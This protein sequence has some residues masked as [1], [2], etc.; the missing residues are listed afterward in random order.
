MGRSVAASAIVLS[1]LLPLASQAA[2]PRTKVLYRFYNAGEAATTPAGGLIPDASGALYG[3]TDTGGAFQSGTVFELT[4]PMAGQTAWTER[5]LYSFGNGT[6][7]KAPAA[8]LLM[9]S[10]GDLYGTTPSGSGA[11]VSGTVFELVPPAAGQ[12]VWTEAILH[13][14]GAG[15]DGALPYAGLILDAGGALYGTALAGGTSGHGIVFKLTPPG[16]G[17]TSWTETVLHNFSGPADG[18]YPEG[19]LLLDKSGTL[20][21]TTESGA[22]CCG[23]VFKLS[24]PVSGKTVWRETILHAFTGEPDGDQP[25]SGL[26]MDRTSALYGTTRAGGAGDCSDN[27]GCGTVFKLSPPA[28]GDSGWTE[29]VI[30]PFQGES[31]G[32]APGGSQP[33]G[34]LVIDAL[35]NLYGTTPSGG[36]GACHFGTGCGTVF[37]LTPPTTGETVWTETVLHSF[38]LTNKTAG[39]YPKPGLLR[40]RKGR[41]FGVTGSLQPSD[42]LTGVAFMLTP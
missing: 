24:P 14:F 17:Q 13:S 36:T 28:S 32:A 30:L 26:V 21:G 33:M 23:S 19:D 2:A 16:T 9:D 7:G 39:V 41:L 11:D 20:Y 12:T 38:S 8:R 10:S 4:P 35:G 40:D 1:L 37:E 6:D 25:Y 18:S 34:D 15:E 42:S 22:G 3:V 5:V 29:T 31:D 27:P